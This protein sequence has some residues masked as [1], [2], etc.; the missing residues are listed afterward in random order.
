MPEN[1]RIINLVFCTDGIFP[2]A[3]GGMQR[4]SRLLIEALAKYPN[5][6]MVV[7]HP[8]KSEKIFHAKNIKEISIDG[9]DV[10]K[11]YLKECNAYS[12]RVYEI[13]K[14]YPNSIIYSQGLS[15]WYKAGEFSDRLIVNPHGLEP[16]QVIGLRAKLIALPFKKIFKTIFRKAK[17]VVSLGGG[18]NQILEKVVSKSK[19]AVLPNAVNLPTEINRKYPDKEEKIKLFFIA[20]FEYNKGIGILLAA[21]DK[22]NELGFEDKIDFYL[23]GKGPLFAGRRKHRR[24]LLKP[25]KKLSTRTGGNKHQAKPNSNNNHNPYS[26][27]PSPCLFTVGQ[28]LP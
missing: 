11:N 16:F 5:I 27:Y 4:H 28:M 9:I 6:N 3:I 25:Y 8:H 21:I 17:V 20:R 2:H 1:D 23:A 26:F 19:I 12:K 7:I 13:L 10:N 14:N 24:T 22:L 18:L 15:V